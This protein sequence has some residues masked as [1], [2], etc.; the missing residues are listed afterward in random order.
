MRLPLAILLLYSLMSI[1]P[2]PSR[3][4]YTSLADMGSAHLLDLQKDIEFQFR[5]SGD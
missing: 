1:Y 5:F 4:K 3:A 2:L